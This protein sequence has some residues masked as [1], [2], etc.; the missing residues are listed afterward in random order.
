MQLG[1][2]GDVCEFL[3]KDKAWQRKGSGITPNLSRI[4]KIVSPVQKAPLPAC[5]SQDFSELG[6]RSL[7]LRGR[8]LLLFLWGVGG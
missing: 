1:P 2:S 6:Q 5:L 8:Q 4:G 3:D 7:F